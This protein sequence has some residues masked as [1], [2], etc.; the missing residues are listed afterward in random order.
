MTVYKTL[1]VSAAIAAVGALQ[2][3]DADYMQHAARYGRTVQSTAEMR[4]RKARF[5]ERSAFIAEANARSGA[6]FEVAHS[7]FSDMTED[8]IAL[9]FS[10]V[11]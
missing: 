4:E 11:P 5:A 3:S 7:A 8:E 6:S 1:V 10:R 9:R 2:I